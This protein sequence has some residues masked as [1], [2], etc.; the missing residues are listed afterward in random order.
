MWLSSGNWVWLL[1]TEN[2]FRN[3]TQALQTF[4]ISRGLTC[5][6]IQLNFDWRLVPWEQTLKIIFVRWLYRD[7]CSLTVNSP[8]SRPCICRDQLLTPGSSPLAALPG[9]IPAGS[10]LCLQTDCCHSS[11][12]PGS[13]RRA[14]HHNCTVVHP[15]DLGTREQDTHSPP[16]LVVSGHKE[17]MLCDHQL[18][19]NE[20][21]PKLKLFNLE[22]IHCNFT[23]CP[24]KLYFHISESNFYTRHPVVDSYQWLLWIVKNP[25]KEPK[26]VIMLRDVRITLGC[27]QKATLYLSFSWLATLP[28]V[29]TGV[30]PSSVVTFNSVV[31]HYNS[32]GCKNG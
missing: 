23:G 14:A 2:P 31:C 22:N 8:W 32:V 10:K 16:V 29:E 3:S 19:V 30:S 7:A 13:R 24:I 26:A 27:C 5:S 28:P 4:N 11:V 21:C 15:P 1:T 12:T 9:E 17:G 25:Q 20:W 6:L 18:S